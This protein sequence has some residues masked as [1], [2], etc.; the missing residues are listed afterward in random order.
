MV[1]RNVIFFIS[2]EK[3]LSFPHPQS[4]LFSLIN[5]SIIPNNIVAQID[6]NMNDDDIS[7]LQN[8]I[9]EVRV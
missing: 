6:I 3:T 8:C 7:R 9:Q 4:L 2:T 1:N 5:W